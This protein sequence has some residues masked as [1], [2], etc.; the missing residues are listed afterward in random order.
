VGKGAKRRAHRPPGS[1]AVDTLRFASP[2]LQ[3]FHMTPMERKMRDPAPTARPVTIRCFTRYHVRARTNGCGKGFAVA[4][5][6]AAEISKLVIYFNTI[7][8]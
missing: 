1:V 2:T 6:S 4:V 8:R 7:C 3:C 5:A